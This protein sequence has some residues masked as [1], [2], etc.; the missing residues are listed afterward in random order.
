M[1]FTQKKKAEFFLAFAVLTFG[2][3]MRFFPHSPNF[4]PVGAISLFAGF[5]FSRRTA[6]FLPLLLMLLSDI[7]LGFYE[8]LVMASVYFS[9]LLTVLLGSYLKKKRQNKPL[10]VFFGALLASLVFF[11]LTNFA[12]WAF[13][14]WYSKDLGGLAQSYF[15]ALPFFKNTLFSNFFYAFVFFGLYELGWFL[16]RKKLPMPETLKGKTT[17][18]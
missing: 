18:F 14:P 11:L 3:L 4:S 2:V 12:V 6:L 5:Y 9:F 16:V 10:K 17:S 1:E 7:F 8:L 15:M 13:T